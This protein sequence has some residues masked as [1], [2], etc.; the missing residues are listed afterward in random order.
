M[1]LP[2]VKAMTSGAQ[3]KIDFCVLNCEPPLMS[4]GSLNKARGQFLAQPFLVAGTVYLSMLTRPLTAQ[5]ACVTPPSGLVAWW[6]LEADGTDVVGG[7][8]GSIVGSVGFISAEVGRGM[9]L[10]NLTGS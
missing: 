6:P 9:N 7:H 3:K 8:N 1:I 4:V 2:F 10:P 5:P